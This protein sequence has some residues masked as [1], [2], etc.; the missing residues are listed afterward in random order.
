MKLLDFH[1][2]RISQLDWV[3]SKLKTT[4]RYNQYSLYSV[5][6]CDSCRLVRATGSD[7]SSIRCILWSWDCGLEDCTG[8]WL[9]IGSFASKN[10]NNS[11]DQWNRFVIIRNCFK[12]SYAICSFPLLPIGMLFKCCTQRS[13]ATGSPICT[14]AVPSLVFRNF[15][16]ATFPV[17]KA[18]E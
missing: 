18:S 16:R 14:M 11:S 12:A 15:I 8:S 9:P 6:E 17:R 13:T 1:L 2:T 5:A 3:L 7:C 10:C 4:F